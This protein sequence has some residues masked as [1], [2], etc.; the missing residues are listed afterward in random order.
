MNAFP[1]NNGGKGSSQ[2]TGVGSK[3]SKGASGNQPLYSSGIVGLGDSV[4]AG[5]SYSMGNAN[6]QGILQSSAKM[7]GAFNSGSAGGP[8]SQQT[9]YRGYSPSK[10]KWKANTIGM[11]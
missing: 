8:G 2:N 9:Q 5:S 3:N 4:H 7:G 11:P 1:D 6:A 10:P